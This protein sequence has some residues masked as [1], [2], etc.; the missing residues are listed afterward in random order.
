MSDSV[1]K[2]YEMVE[3]GEIAPIKKNKIKLT[4]EIAI[5]EWEKYYKHNKE[6]LYNSEDFEIAYGF[7][8]WLQNKKLT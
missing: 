2:Y 3:S 4:D 7:V 6:I 1:K 8:I 5:S